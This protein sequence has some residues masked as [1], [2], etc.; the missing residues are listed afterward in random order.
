MKSNIVFAVIGVF[1]GCTDQI[2]PQA[3]ELGLN[4]PRVHIVSPARGAIAG[5]VTTLHVTGTVGDDSTSIPRVTVNGVAATVAPGG[6]W[7]ADVAVATGTNL[8]HAIATD[9]HGNT[10]SETRAVVAGPMVSLDRHVGNGIQA[11]FSAQ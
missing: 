4:A 7:V 8:V 3:P 9:A 11:T 6:T 5:D 1:V 2:P 10:G